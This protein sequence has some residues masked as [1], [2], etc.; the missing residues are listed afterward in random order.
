M[1][2]ISS[3]AFSDF[4]DSSTSSDSE[5]KLFQRKLDSKEEDSK[6]ERKISKFKPPVRTMED[7]KHEEIINEI[8]QIK[9]QQSFQSQKDFTRDQ[10][11]EHEKKLKR[12][13]K[14][15]KETYYLIKLYMIIQKT[16][17]IFLKNSI[18][19]SEFFI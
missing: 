19:I 10:D 3:K 5:T 17:T 4:K 2:I 16:S 8:D 7:E 9:L 14:K 15:L 6:R 12:K 18:D 13:E 1:K 11:E